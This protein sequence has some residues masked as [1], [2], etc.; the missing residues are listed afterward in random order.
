MMRK[1][2]CEK[3][4]ENGKVAS[5]ERKLKEWENGFLGADQGEK[6]DRNE[7]NE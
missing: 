7:E 6:I 1:N 3:P 5:K 2:G 4:T